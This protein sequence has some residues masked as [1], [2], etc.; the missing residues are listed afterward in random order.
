MHCHDFRLRWIH[1]SE[2]LLVHRGIF[3]SS[4]SSCCSGTITC[5][6]HWALICYF[7]EICEVLA[8]ILNISPFE[9]YIKI[10]RNTAAVI[11]IKLDQMFRAMI[12]KL[13]NLK[14]EVGF[15]AEKLSGNIFVFA[16]VQKAT[17]AHRSVN[18]LYKVLKAFIDKG[19]LLTLEFEGPLSFGEVVL[20]ILLHFWLDQLLS[21]QDPLV[22][23]VEEGNEHEGVG[24]PIIQFILLL[25]FLPLFLDVL[26]DENARIHVLLE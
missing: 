14:Q 21:L 26:W 1:E 10:L 17:K 9:I 19:L 5:N 24:W 3:L 18:G 6:G 2:S 15:T 22:D 16:S 11:D 20:E 12:H 4:C 13:V 23:G 8:F 7:V 25:L